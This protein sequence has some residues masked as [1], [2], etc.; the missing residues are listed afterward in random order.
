MC[1]SSNISNSIK[2]IYIYRLVFHPSQDS[3]VWFGLTRREQLMSPECSKNQVLSFAKICIHILHIWVT[4]DIN[5]TFSHWGEDR[6]E[7][8]TSCKFSHS[9]PPV[10]IPLEDSPTK[11]VSLLG[12]SYWWDEGSPPPLAEN[13]L[14]PPPG[15]IP[16]VE[17]SSLNL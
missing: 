2:P 5:Q 12:F 1:V 8:P 7:L 13:L 16:S 15:K 6:E 11:V 9:F 14:I 3:S 17:F 10:K 4:H